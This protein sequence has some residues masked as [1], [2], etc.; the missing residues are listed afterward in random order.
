MAA[1]QLSGLV[2]FDSKIS[3]AL[4]NIFSIVPD[5]KVASQQMKVN[6]LDQAQL[7]KLPAF[8]PSY[9]LRDS[10]FT[11]VNP[12]NNLSAQ[13]DGAN[14]LANINPQLVVD[15]VTN[16]DTVNSGLGLLPGGSNF[17]T[18]GRQIAINDSLGVSSRQVDTSVV[19]DNNYGSKTKDNISPLLS[20][21]NNA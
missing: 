2:G 10:G 5:V 16:I 6:N 13:T 21:M 11:G 3:Q 15:Q 7:A 18:E 1:S 12:V 8:N 4:T 9:G 19:S 14:P 20:A 17:S